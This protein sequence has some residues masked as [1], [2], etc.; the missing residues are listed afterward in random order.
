MPS[1]AKTVHYRA[2]ARGDDDNDNILKGKNP[3]ED[4]SAH[5][6]NICKRIIQLIFNMIIIHAGLNLESCK[7]GLLKHEH[8][9]P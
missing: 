4:Q 7:C 9:V 2:R 8:C 3:K 1:I 6:G 5:L